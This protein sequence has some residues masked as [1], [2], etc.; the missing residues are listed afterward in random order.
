MPL[1]FLIRVARQS[2]AFFPLISDETI[3]VNLNGT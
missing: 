1:S 2:L 3:P